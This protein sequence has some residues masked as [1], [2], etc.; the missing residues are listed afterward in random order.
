LN[1]CQTPLAATEFD[2]PALSRLQAGATAAVFGRVAHVYRLYEGEGHGFRKA[3]TL[4][5]YYQTAERFLREQVIY[6]V[7]KGAL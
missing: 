2:R 5:D 7:S 3:E 6:N 1:I 4:A